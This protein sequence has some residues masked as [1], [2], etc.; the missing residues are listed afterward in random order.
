[1]WGK[2]P[3]I[4]ELL[5]MQT[6]KSPNQSHSKGSGEGQPSRTESFDNDGSILPK[7]TDHTLARLPCMP[8]SG[9]VPRLQAQDGAQASL[10]PGGC[11]QAHFPILVSAGSVGT[12]MRTPS[13]Q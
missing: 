5:Q 3:E 11:A 1:M 7:H 4:C 6:K 8:I 9:T 13:W 10:P 12:G 2:E